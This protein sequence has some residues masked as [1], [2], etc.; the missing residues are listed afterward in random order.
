MISQPVCALIAGIF[1]AICF[2]V[3]RF[4]K[5]VSQQN[6]TPRTDAPIP[7]FGPKSDD[8]KWLGDMDYD[9]VITIADS[10]TTELLRQGHNRD[11]IGQDVADITRSIVEALE[12]E[13]SVRP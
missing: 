2:A 7:L 5:L 6:D 1:G 4:S 10:V 9:D 8:G 11:T 13:P 12:N 3:G